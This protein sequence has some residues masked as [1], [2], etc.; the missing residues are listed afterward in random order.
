VTY[1][2]ITP[3]LS[4]QQ[5]VKPWGSKMFKDGKE[6]KHLRGRGPFW[7]SQV[8][9]YESPNSLLPLYNSI[10]EI[11]EK[12]LNQV[13]IEEPVI[14][15]LPNGMFRLLQGEY[16]QKDVLR[17]W[18][19]VEFDHGSL[20]CNSLS[21]DKRLT[22]TLAGLPSAFH[23]CEMV[24]LLSNKAFMEG[25]PNHM[26]LHIYFRLSK[27]MLNSQ[28]KRALTG[29]EG[30]DI[31]VFSNG[32]RHYVSPPLLDNTKRE[33]VGDTVKYFQGKALDL[34]E[35][36]QDEDYIRNREHINTLTAVTRNFVNFTPKGETMDELVRLAKEGFFDRFNRRTE[37]FKIIKRAEWT[38]QNGSAVIEAIVDSGKGN[39]TILGNKATKESLT[40]ML[41]DIQNDL[42][43]HFQ[44]S[45]NSQ[46]YDAV[47]PDPQHHDLV[48]ADLSELRECIS[49]NLEEGNKVNLIAKFPHGSGKTTAIIPILDEELSKHLGRPARILYVCTLRSIVRGTSEELMFECYITEEGEI[50]QHVI[51]NAER[52]GICIRSLQRIE[53][54]N[55]P[56]DALIRD[57]SEQIGLWSLWQGGG[58]V[59]RDY[60]YLN[61]VATH[62]DLKL[63]VLMDADAGELTY[64]QLR[65]NVLTESDKTVLFE[66]ANSWIHA[67]EQK[68][69]WYRKP[70]EILNQLYDDA[71]TNNKFCFVHV[72]FDD[73]ES[74]PKLTAL[75]NAFNDLSGKEIA[76]AFWK[77]TDRKTKNRLFTEKDKFLPE[78]YEQGIRIVFV[79][80]IIVSGWRYKG[81]PHFD[82]TYGIYLHTT[83]T[84]PLII[85]RTQRVTHVVDHHMYVNPQ[86]N[87]TNL[88]ELLKGY[89]Y[90]TEYNKLEHTVYLRPNDAAAKE[91]IA[92]SGVVSAKH[93]D[94]IKLHTLYLWEEF[95]GQHIFREY[96]DTRRD[97]LDI[98]SEAISEAKQ[99][100]K[101]RISSEIFN[102]EERL[103]RLIECFTEYEESAG[104]WTTKSKPNDVQEVM[105][106]I[107]ILDGTRATQAM[108]VQVCHLLNT[109]EE[110]WKKWELLGAPWEADEATLLELYDYEMRT[111]DTTPKRSIRLLGTLLEE[112]KAQLPNDQ[113]ELLNEWLTGKI[114]KPIVIETAGVDVSAFNRIVNSHYDIL[115]ERLKPLFGDGTKQMDKFAIKLFRKILQCNVKV[116]EAKNGKVVELKHEIVYHYQKNR[117]LPKGQWNKKLHRR[118][119]S[120][121]A[122]RIR[123]EYEL[124][125]IEEEYLKNAGKIITI[126]MP[127]VLP[128]Y[129]QNL[130]ERSYAAQHPREAVETTIF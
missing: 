69:H 26:S 121:L 77:G 16:L 98:L 14:H 88:D 116:S 94:N 53:N 55:V 54:R 85:Q 67:L 40:T 52:L 86:S 91:L 101:Y 1:T 56:F 31:S 79:S 108:A 48:K 10:R 39:G 111:V 114:R 29:L 107:Q 103:N 73:K 47:L 113:G 27:P 115:K 128:Y 50:Q 28:I 93:R 21:L 8:A 7:W 62:K 102:D 71:V 112:L 92:E 24:V 127:K 66:G 119:E 6:I 99:A 64:T 41:E 75:V 125:D 5:D 22:S 30:V 45:L 78:L 122:Q 123:D 100:E 35:L 90:D 37:H 4:S 61:E 18:I 3:E 82:A 72:D 32:R 104:G 70:R 81:K 118:A 20:D 96:D 97:E 15:K 58:D 38:N 13:I 34:Q 51:T 44:Y 83:Q 43:K 60:S 42:Q 105:E 80:P 109:T 89:Y 11:Q 126:T 110:D 120:I 23:Q 129:L 33:I 76:V 46:K 84:A 19:L 130:Y 2:I 57:E 17:N 25:Y 117:Q 65:R 68:M 87:Y 49:R 36:E 106:L 95:G 74:N 9:R 12:Q 59:L 124:S 63:N